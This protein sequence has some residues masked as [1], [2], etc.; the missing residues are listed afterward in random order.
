MSPRSSSETQSA[1]AGRVEPAPIV[2]EYDYEPVK[3]LP[4]FL[5]VG[6]RMLWQGS[7]DW[8]ALALRVFHARKI[9]IYFAIL[10]IW[11]LASGIND[12][13]TWGQA[14]MA[15]VPVLP[16]AGLGVGL[17][18]LVAWLYAKSTVY[19]ITSERVVMRFGLALTLTVNLPLK[20]VKSADLKLAS[21]GTGDL[22]LNFDG[23]HRVSYVYMWPFVRPWRMARPQPM[24]RGLKNPETVA[25][26][27]TS[28]LNGR[29]VGAV[30]ATED[31]DV[32]GLSPQ[33]AE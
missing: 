30:E 16:V 12:G 8:K 1:T 27:L 4:N 21:D 29:P 17:M 22:P 33:P 24:L 26:V 19:T 7:P 18:C 6:E 3:G 10:V 32:S 14:L 23:P 15:I 11:R 5:P 28:A 9:A 20:L 13:E 31:R 25:T 2:G